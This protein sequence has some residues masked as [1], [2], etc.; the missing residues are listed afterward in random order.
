MKEVAVVTEAEA[1][2]EAEA[3]EDVRDEQAH[4]PHVAGAD[5]AAVSKVAQPWERDGGGV[6]GAAGGRVRR[7]VQMRLGACEPGG[8][9]RRR[10]WW[11]WRRRW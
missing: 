9:W 10:R 6:S 5:E 8:G 11:W 1:E 4:E 3:G 2:A 7:C